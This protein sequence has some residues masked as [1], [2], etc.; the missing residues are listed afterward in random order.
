M[1][2]FNPWRLQIIGF[3]PDD[4]LLAKRY[5][6]REQ[7]VTYAEKFAREGAWVAPDTYL[8]PNRIKYVKLVEVVN[9]NPQV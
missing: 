6:T 7:A 4:F 1:N 5:A 2:K 8:P 9:E 3:T